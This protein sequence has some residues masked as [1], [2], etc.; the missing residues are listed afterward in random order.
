MR[1]ANLHPLVTAATQ[2][3]AAAFLSVWLI[4]GSASAGDTH[5]QAVELFEKQ[6]RPVLIAECQR[7]H[8]E[9][10]QQGNLRLDSANGWVAGGDSGP[11]IVPGDLDSV[12]LQAIRYESVELEMPPKGKLPAETIAAF[13][14][15]VQLGAVDPRIAAPQTFGDEPGPPTI[16]QG[17]HFW[18]FQPI[19]DPMPPE[20][21]ASNWPAGDIDRFILAQL[22]EQG[23]SPSPPADPPTLLRRVCYD[24]IGL[25]PTIEQ[26]ESFAADPSPQAYESIV[27]GLLSSEQF[28]QRWGRHWLDVVRYAESSGGGRT[29]MFSDAWRYRDYVIESF[30]QDLPFDQF[31]RQQIAGD[32]LPADDWQQRRNNLTATAF[33]MLGPTNYEL[34][35]KDVLEMDV[36]DEQLDTM[37]KALLGMTIGCAR[38]HDHK[39]DPIPTTDYYAMAGILKSSKVL[40]HDNVSSWNTARL[41]LP[42][43]Q[44]EQARRL[45]EELAR[46]EAK[47]R[48]TKKAW[49]A[50]GGVS[51]PESTGKSIDPGSIEGLVVDEDQSQK[52]GEWKTSDSVGYFVG[53]SYSYTA[54]QPGAQAE[55]RAELPTAGRYEVLVSYTAHRNRT[56]KARYQITHADDTV[57]ITVNQRQ[58]PPIE[59][60]FYSLGDYRFTVDQ[61]P[62]VTVSGENADGALIADAVVWRPTRQR[63]EAETQAFAEQLRQR[64]QLKQRLDNLTQ[65]AKQ[66]E[67]S[68]PQGPSA[69]VIG[70]RENPADIH[71]AI[72]G[73]T[74]QQGDLVRRGALR[75]ASW[76]TSPKIHPDHSGRRQLAEWIVDPRNP[77]TAR[78]IANRVWYWLIGRGIVPTVDNFGA[79]GQP[80]SHPELLDHLATSLID[81][82][83]SIKRLIH[84]IVTSQTYR[85]SSARHH[86][87]A[88]DNLGGG[89]NRYLSRMNRK[90]LRAEDIRDSILWV[91]GDLESRHGGSTIKPGTKSEYGY[92]FTSTRRSVYVPVFRNTLPQI[93]EVFD[94]ADPNIQRGQRSASIVS[95]QALLMMNHPFVIENARAAARNLL[96]T[97]GLT[98]QQRIERAYQQVLARPPRET[99]LRVAFDLLADFDHNEQRHSSPA[100]SQ[101]QGLAMLYQ[102]LFQCIDFRYLN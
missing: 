50:A 32:L 70:E 15:W 65:Q 8:G 23:L 83:W 5:D 26:I 100:T 79:T 54:S 89:D 95:S 27:S 56:T 58:Q 12:L 88:G 61:Q 30:N 98:R 33:L 20:V 38:C 19:A 42:P 1:R 62:I 73:S 76:E 49:I 60:K 92:Q 53:S 85:Q 18:S 80:P 34:Q 9:E 72:G 10:K 31:V 43:A 11:A 22:E 57:S 74:H 44:A 78:V 84:R 21:A 14:K 75:V 37:G 102:V 66:I 77:L 51:V 91:A 41:P 90:R 40:I 2:L 16:E 86:D 25:P 7:C 94:F 93:F 28:G 46:V 6:I 99:E 69:M 101:E 64:R 52:T 17:R 82:G 45:R 47:Q 35:D 87:P 67:A 3:W 13:E 39:F 71:V 48:K 55:Y 97:P 59:G 68:I 29:L 36:V 63:S 81:D 4:G 96:A 24:L